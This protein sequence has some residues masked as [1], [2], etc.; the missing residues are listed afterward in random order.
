MIQLY[1]ER[2]YE[3]LSRRAANI[4]SAQVI[5][6]PDSVLGL[7]TGSTPEGIYTQLVNWYQKNDLSFRDTKTVNLD[8]YVGLS[9]EDEN[10]YRYY[11]N[12]HLFSHINIDTK[13]T[14][15]PNGLA[16]DLH[17]EC[18]RYNA[19]IREL[20]GIDMQLLG[21]GGNGHI[22]F[23]E[24]ATVFTKNTHVVTLC[25]STIETNAR[26]FSSVDAV[27]RQALTMGIGSI[28]KAKHV[29]L[30][31]S[32]QAKAT[33]LYRTFCEPVSAEMPG[34]ILQF[35]PNVTVIADEAAMREL[36]AS[37]MNITEL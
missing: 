36:D 33:A 1:R 5:L 22:G 9:P 27:P 17:E 37:G 3:R 15:V 26:F 31:A 12:H 8:E 4:I 16:E 13:N 35:H 30:V 25:E 24:P 14:W 34:S 6:K 28:M 19:K 32:G 20:G 18:T 7:A 2:D 23:N 11:M 29:L 10:S 21:L